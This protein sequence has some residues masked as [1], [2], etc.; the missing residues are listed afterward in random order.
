MLNPSTFF[1]F[2]WISVLRMH[3]G[4]RISLKGTISL[5]ATCKRLPLLKRSKSWT[6][7]EIF[8]LSHIYN[9]DDWEA[10]TC[11]FEGYNAQMCPFYSV[12][13][14]PQGKFDQR[15]TEKIFTISLSPHVLFLSFEWSM[16]CL[17][18]ILMICS[19]HWSCWSLGRDALHPPPFLFQKQI[20]QQ[21]TA[22]FA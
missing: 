13:L 2:A 3:D 14:F 20:Q 7:D 10:S 21:K 1:T 17:L 12:S 6:S 18:G 5:W 16:W 22:L 11:I 15:E 19:Q 9:G 4:D 8:V